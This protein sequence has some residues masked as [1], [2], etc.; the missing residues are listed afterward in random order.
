MTIE[1]VLRRGDEWLAKHREHVRGVFTDRKAGEIPPATEPSGEDF[2][3]PELW[4]DIHWA[5]YA[6]QRKLKL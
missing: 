6:Q 4:K 2:R 5:W 1:E 3:R